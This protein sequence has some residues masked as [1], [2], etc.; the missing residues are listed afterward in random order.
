VKITEIVLTPVAF[1]DPPLLNSAG[2]HEPWAL[3]TIVEIHTDE[4]ISGLGETYGDIAHLERLRKVVPYLIGLDVFALGPMH[5]RVAAALGGVTGTDTHGLTGQL[6]APGTVDR[7][8]SPF[9]VA[10]LDIQGR[11]I[12]RPVVD[13]LGGKVRDAV[14]YSAYL[15]YKWAGH[16]KE[17]IGDGEPDQW[18]EALDPAGVVAQAQQLIDEYGFKSIKLKG[19]VFPPEQEI[20]AIK[21][22]REAFPGTPLRLDPN[23]AWTPAT[24][25]KVAEQLDGVVEY[26]ED[27]SPE[28][29]G[30]AEVAAS[31][32]MPL[33]TNMCVV[34]FEHI[35]P[36][37]KVNAV[38]VILSDHHYWGGLTRSAHLAAIC[39]TFGIGLSMHS[40][41]HL[42]ISLAAMTHLAG[43]TPNLSYACDTHY[44]WNAVDD[45]V[46]PGV[47]NFSDGALAVPSAPG[48][49]IELDRDA[50]AR[51]AENYRTCGIVQRNDTGY[52]QQFDPSYE[53]KRPRW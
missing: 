18:G 53:R 43:A 30:M 27:P 17:K 35:A 29:E 24:G 41:S 15:F 51:L 45:V 14:P 12:G 8:Y 23:A 46:V 40:N 13:L 28:I 11:A 36:S 20:E 9:E 16:P 1:R 34:S 42:G 4:G 38:Q 6:S 37:V 32:P 21:A 2:V 39:S 50:L 33:A 49:G 19:G 3:R 7:V 25:I 26:L 31:A 44:P 52:M 5:Q 22:L 10:C 48:L 47:L